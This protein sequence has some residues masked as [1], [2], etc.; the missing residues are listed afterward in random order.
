MNEIGRDGGDVSDADAVVLTVPWSAIADAL[1]SVT[2]ID[3]KGVLDATNFTRGE[4]PDFPS[5]AHQVKSIVGGPVAK[6]FN[7]NFARLFGE[8]AKQP[9]PPGNI[10]CADEEAREVTEQL[11]RDAGYQPVDAG[12]LD[13]ARALEDALPALFAVSQAGGGP[14]FYSFERPGWDAEGR[15]RGPRHVDDQAATGWGSGR[16]TTVSATAMI[17]STGRSA[18]EACL[19]IASGLVA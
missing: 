19:R 12:G 14:V 9:S 18:S 2:G 8:V 11:I 4:R 6:T 17:S 7:L 1:E 15:S 16:T 3:G 10:Y 13:N 5:L